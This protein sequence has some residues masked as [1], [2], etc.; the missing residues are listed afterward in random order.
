MKRMMKRIKNRIENRLFHMAR[1]FGLITYRK[2]YVPRY[3]GTLCAP[4]NAIKTSMFGPK[5][6][7]FNRYYIAIEGYHETSGVVF[8]PPYTGIY[9][10][11]GAS[12]IGKSGNH[13]FFDKPPEGAA[14]KMGEIGKRP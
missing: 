1:Y 9:L 5:P 4:A 6:S 3:V 11:D 8:M 10:E 14:L 13:V 7:W 12:L 2:V